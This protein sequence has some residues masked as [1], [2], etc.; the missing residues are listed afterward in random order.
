MCHGGH[1]T[2]GVHLPRFGLP[3]RSLSAAVAQKPAMSQDKEF[4]LA[5]LDGIEAL[6]P[7]FDAAEGMKADLERRGWSPTVAESV[8]HQW[9]LNVMQRIWSS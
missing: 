5:L 4:M 8:A 9:L 3:V 1:S 2:A 6:S 7:I